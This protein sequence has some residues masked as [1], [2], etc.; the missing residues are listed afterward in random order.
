MRIGVDAHAI[1][2]HLTGNEVY[3]RSLL[4]AFAAQGRDCEIVAYVSSL[5]S[6]ASIPASIRTRRVALN[7]FLRLGYDL[8]MKVRQGRPDLLHRQCTAPLACPG[9]GG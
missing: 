3:V 2:R 4:N 6:C 8:S 5:E 9:P 7:P 1:G